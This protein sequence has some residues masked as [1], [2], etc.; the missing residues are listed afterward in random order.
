[1]MIELNGWAIGFILGPERQRFSFRGPVSIVQKCD[2]FA[3]NAPAEILIP[4]SPKC[5]F[6]GW[7]VS[8]NYL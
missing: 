4:I 6:E 1:M 7:H 2:W 3:A 8:F 5:L